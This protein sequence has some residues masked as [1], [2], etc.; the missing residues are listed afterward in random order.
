MLVMGVPICVS[1][2]AIVETA[3]MG[4]A[5]PLLLLD[6]G[7]KHCSSENMLLQER[8]LRILETALYLVQART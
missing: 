1:A 6:P 7:L 5:P 2:V 8:C 3:G 4:R